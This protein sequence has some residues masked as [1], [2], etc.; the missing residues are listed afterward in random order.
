MTLSDGNV[1]AISLTA[2]GRG[3]YAAV[4]VGDDTASDVR[5]Y[6]LANDGTS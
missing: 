5:L 1:Q 2:N 3:F 4:T 6:A